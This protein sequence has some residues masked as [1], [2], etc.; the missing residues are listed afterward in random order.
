[1]GY[2]YHGGE[3]VCD[4]C[5]TPGAVKRLCPAWVT[6]ANGQRSRW[7]PPPAL[8]GGC[9]TRGGGTKGVHGKCKAAAAEDQAREDGRKAR[10]AD[11]EL[12]VSSALSG[13]GRY[14]PAGL[15]GA[16]F[17]G[18]NGA[19]TWLLV[20]GEAYSREYRA[21]G[22]DLALSDFPGMPVWEDNPDVRRAREA[23]QVHDYLVAPVS[24]CAEQFEAFEVPA[25]SVG[26]ASAVARQR[27]GHE[28]YSVVRAD[29]VSRPCPEGCGGAVAGGRHSVDVDYCYALSQQAKADAGELLD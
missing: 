3:L 22:L 25:L 10:L 27:L 9:F 13:A 11:G 4:S 20:P 21:R 2:C 23:G 1:M 12:F 28:H 5:G 16:Q 8:C 7:C 18:L 19:R 24:V 26:A 15:V 17:T 14:V 6:A 29:T